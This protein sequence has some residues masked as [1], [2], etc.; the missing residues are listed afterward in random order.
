MARGLTPAGFVLVGLC[1]LLPFA[2]VSCDAPGGFGRSAP[3]GTTSYTGFDL[4]TGG[5]PEVTADRV[6]PPEQRQDDR[7]PPQVLAGTVLGLSG[8][9]LALAAIRDRRVRRASVAVV[10]ALAAVAHLANQYRVAALLAAQVRDQLTVPMPAGKSAEDFVQTGS[11]F[12]AVLLLL[13]GIAT[14]NGAGLLKL[15]R[16]RAASTPA[17]TGW[18]ASE[19]G[20]WP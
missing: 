2:A 16:G 12:G 7:L 3:G 17:R 13:A 9:G 14:S 6:R 11:G 15:R 1:F 18:P 8:A 5:E 20:P 19:P 4:A 10:A